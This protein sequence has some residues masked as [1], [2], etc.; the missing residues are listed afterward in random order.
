MGAQQVICQQARSCT[1]T[2]KLPY[3]CWPLHCCQ[4][5]DYTLRYHSI[6][7]NRYIRYFKGHTGKVTTLCMSPKTDMFLSAAEDK[8]VRGGCWWFTLSCFLSYFTVARV[9]SE[10]ASSTA[11]WEAACEPIQGQPV[12]VEC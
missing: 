3:A 6:Y 9:A 2:P 12:V 5:A 1:T 7:D 11:C 8:Q 10:L 4:G